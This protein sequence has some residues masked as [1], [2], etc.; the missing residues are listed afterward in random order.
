MTTEARN[1][2]IGDR[3]KSGSTIQEVTSMIIISDKAIAYRTKR[4][5]PD[6]YDGNFFQR[7]R[8]STRI[9]IV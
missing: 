2:K 1:L 8:L 5:S 3:Y 6:V 4:V 9:E 7:K